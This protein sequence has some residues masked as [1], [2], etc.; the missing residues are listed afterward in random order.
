MADQCGASIQESAQRVH[1]QTIELVDSQ[2]KSLDEETQALE[3]L[4]IKG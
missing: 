3:D 4:V 2:M 1:A